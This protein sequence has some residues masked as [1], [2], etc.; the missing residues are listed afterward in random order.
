MSLGEG[1]NASSFC[2][3]WCLNF[4]METLLLLTCT[5]ILTTNSG[6]YI[7]FHFQY[8]V[9]YMPSTVNRRGNRTAVDNILEL[10]KCAYHKINYSNS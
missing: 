5:K 2:H 9:D 7:F 10:I 4:T 8:C 6:H 3:G 1:S